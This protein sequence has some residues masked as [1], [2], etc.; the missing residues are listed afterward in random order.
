MNKDQIVSLVT[1]ILKIAGSALA[2]HGATKAASFLNTEDVTGAI[3]TVVTVIYSHWYNGQPQAVK[4]SPCS[5][6]G[7]ETNITGK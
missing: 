1:S 5:A 6:Q 3:I 7:S 2:A 4:P